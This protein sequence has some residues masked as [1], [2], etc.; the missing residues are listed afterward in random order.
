MILS[1][2]V[3]FGWQAFFAPDMDQRVDEDEVDPPAEEQIDDEELAEQPQPDQPDPEAEP[4][5]AEPEPQPQPDEPDPDQVDEP[6][7]VA[8]PEEV[9]EP[10]E[11]DDQ[12]APAIAERQ[13]VIVTNNVEFQFS[14][15]GAALT[16]AEITAPRQYAR[17]TGGNLLRPFYQEDLEIPGWPFELSFDDGNIELDGDEMFELVEDKSERVGTYEDDERLGQYESITYRY[18]DPAG[19]FTVD[20]TFSPHPDARDDEQF[21]LDMDIS[22]E[23]QIGDD[24]GALAG[25]PQLDIFARDDPEREDHLLDFRPDLLEGV[26]HNAEDTERVAFENL[27]GYQQFSQYSVI[28]A[29]TDTRYFLTAAVPIDG[30]TACSFDFGNDEF[31]HT[32]IYH[33]GITIGPGDSWQQS[34][35]LFMG[36]KHF[37]ILNRAGHDLQESVDYG[38]FSFLARPL[39]W[40]LSRLYNF[41]MNW[42]LAIILLTFI[43]KMVLWPITGKAYTSAEKMKQI[44]PQIKEIREKYEDDQ[45]RMTEETM[46]AF[47]ENDVSPL[48]CLPLLL[49]LPILYGLFVMIYNSVELYQAEFLYF[50]DLSAPD[51]YYALPV[52]MGAVMFIQQKITMSASATGNPQMKVVMK[53]MP[54]AFTGFMLFLPAGLVLYYLLNLLIGLLQ[55]FLIKRKFR[56]AEEAGEDV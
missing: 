19:N 51:P 26:C 47:R 33:D 52:L 28:W 8:E 13:D 23:S 41:T 4:D 20:K 43:I 7:E 42:G 31:I 12:D 38:L 46:K 10:E 36:P 17:G 3:I 15:R 2:L 1:A 44:Q 9:I 39:R 35:K 55:Q 11:V 24:G 49:Q 16:R 14:N 22:V 29:G 5:E 56:K 18:T 27:E 54:V 21:A 40:S 53:V 48:G 34:Y 45:Q 25:Q 6:E 50:A 37:D 30:A 32:R